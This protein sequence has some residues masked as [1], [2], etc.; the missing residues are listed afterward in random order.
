MQKYNG[1][2]LNL[3]NHQNFLPLEVATTH[4]CK[5]RVY[6]SGWLSVLKSVPMTIVYTL[7]VV[8]EY[9]F[10]EILFRIG[11]IGLI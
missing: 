10:P 2:N 6:T 8:L 5:L 7:Y 4:L 1:S 9:T 3:E 11:G